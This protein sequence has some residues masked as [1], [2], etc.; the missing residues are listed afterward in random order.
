MLRFDTLSGELRVTAE[1]AEPSAAADA[2]GV[3]TASLPLLCMDFPLMAG[4]PL[5]VAWE[6]AVSL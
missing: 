1:E 2:G 3:G 4:A 6:Q 5:L